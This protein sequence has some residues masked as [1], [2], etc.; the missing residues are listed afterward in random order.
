MEGQRIGP[1]MLRRRL[2]AGGMGEVWEAWDERLHRRVAVKRLS[3]SG[4]SPSRERLLREART[5]A[6][7]AHPSIVA[8]HDI[9][10]E[11]GSLSLV[12]ELVEGT[13]VRQLLERDGP[14]PE[15]QVID[16][17]VQIASALAAAHERAII[18][19]DLKTENV[20]RTRD[21]RI[22]V[23]D[24]G[25][26]RSPD[27]EGTLAPDGQI[28]GTLR[29]MSPEQALGRDV[30]PRTDLFSLGVLLYEAATGVSPFRGDGPASTLQRICTHRPPPVRQL[31]PSLSAGLSGVIDRLLE[32]DR[33]HR[34]PDARAVEEALRA[35]QTS[36]QSPQEL[37]A[38]EPTAGP[39]EAP[40][41]PPATGS[42]APVPA[43]RVLAVLI[44]VLAGALLLFLLWPRLAPVAEQSRRIAVLR[45]VVSGDTA[46]PLTGTAVRLAVLRALAGAPRM[47]VVPF[48]EADAA[49][50]LPLARLA[51]ALAADEI[52]LTRV[53]CR[54]LLCQVQIERRQPDKVLAA[55]G[56]EAAA[57]RL[58]LVN[59]GVEDRVRTIYGFEGRARTALSP[60]DHRAYLELWQAF[61]ASPNGLATRDILQKLGALRQRAPDFVELYLL[62]ARVSRLVWNDSR[63]DR[64]LRRTLS[65][66]A[67][68]RRLAR[69]SPMPDLL[70]AGLWLD[71]GQLDQAER[72]IA[73]LVRQHPGHPM[74]LQI[75]AQAA[76]RR[77][78][79]A[80]ALR[81][82]HRAVELCPS[83]QQRLNLARS[84]QRQGKME[85]ARAQLEAV[86]AILPGQ[87]R[88]LALL[89]QIELVSGD[90]ERA[91][92]IFAH[93]AESTPRATLW[94]N[95][96]LAHLFSGRTAEAAAAYRRAEAL[97]PDH[98]GVA[99]NLADAL[100]LLGRRSEADALYERVLA[101][102]ARPAPD[103]WQVLTVRGQAL[104]HLGRSREAVTALQSALRIAPG[105]AQ[106]AYEAALIY[107]LVGDRT[108]ALASA[109]SALR[110]GV[111]P[112]WFSL[113][114]FRELRA[115]PELQDFLG[116][117]SS[118]PTG[119]S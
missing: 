115:D 44:A 29:A 87:P 101:L 11:A 41:A 32:K 116:G 80:E 58:L 68:A 84:A 38:G 108:S 118:P 78:D 59:E 107:T 102:T 67:T 103:D 63:Q 22:K 9:V 47:D 39:E 31:V 36:A 88:A 79:G 27:A 34:P 71:A 82:M 33:A 16:L 91:T 28:V 55:V 49:G 17:G 26:A 20:M 99:L 56:F 24:F 3:P 13:T 43:R 12:L 45:P 57:D 89:G 94:S 48:E 77:G 72:L 37:T 54:A 23:L 46:D 75:Q 90:L 73:D 97:A 66:L 110:G 114:W 106:T 117:H 100:A 119:V 53:E 1:Y 8:I 52:V 83:W 10:E 70:E 60:E 30:D 112:R 74:V 40:P 96:G 98:P 6:A 4:S 2:G 25:I 14:L 21:G 76:E 35:L 109:E 64:D 15:A 7:L 111:Q 50:D 86:L 95:L 92:R 42:F 113:P 61:D 5:V 81:L 105:S 18:H 65:L 19:R 69:D 104:A 51:A 85:E 62:E 93:L